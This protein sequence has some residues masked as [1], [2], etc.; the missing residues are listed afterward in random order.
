[1]T[2]IASGTENGKLVSELVPERVLPKV[3]NTFGLTSAYVFIICWIA[4]ASLMATAG[5]G[6]IPMWIAGYVLFLIPAGLAV[7]EL[8]NLWPA[9]GGVYIWAYRTMNETSAFFGGFLSWIPVILVGVSGPAV[10]LS[11][12]ELAFHIT[13]IS[14]AWSVI[15]QVLFL[16]LASS[17]ALRKLI[18]GQRLMN[19]VFIIYAVI[20]A[21]V[22]LTGI[23]HAGLHGSATP[24]VSHDLLTFNFGK[25]GWVFGAILLYLVGVET[26]FNMGAEFLSVKRSAT[27][28]IL[29][30]SIALSLIYMAGTVGTMLSLPTDK[31]DVV[32]GFAASLKVGVPG[33]AEIAAILIAVVVITALMTYESAYSR[34]VFVSGLE[35]HLPRLFTHLN[36]RTRNPVTAILIQTC[37][38][39]VLVIVLNSGS[40]LANVVQYITGGLSVV[41]LFSGFFF[42]I[43]VVIA[44]YKYKQRYKTERFWRIPGGLVGVW[45]VA[46]VGSVG[47]GLGIYYS[48]TL[49]FGVGIAQGTWMTW[50]GGIVAGC[51][52]AALVVYYF[53]R[54]AASK[55]S[56]ADS[57]AH[58]AVLETSAPAASAA[59]PSPGAG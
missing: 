15:A 53:G 45:I 59:E 1:M 28:M 58:L 49:P 47:T 11:Y 31:I 36:P 27:R 54:R 4:G 24:V 26:P 10:V 12:F 30:G 44:R 13:N 3:L 56:E 52:I 39:T 38:S 32:N 46:I 41:W 7:A 19:T 21:A 48:F 40:N 23:V 34:L 42:F 55:L 50:V 5:W 33:F 6:S 17:L 18:V 25:L 35:R 22:L 57:L 8:A 14:L 16:W 29:W 37:L 2:S 9:Q 51:V 43:P 20:V